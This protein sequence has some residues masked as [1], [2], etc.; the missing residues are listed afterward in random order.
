MNEV[1]IDR[2]IDKQNKFKQKR[3]QQLQQIVWKQSV[4]TP[5]ERHKYGTRNWNTLT[6]FIITSRMQDFCILLYLLLDL[7]KKKISI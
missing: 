4:K 3:Q 5:R 1:R 6:V 7:Q 2:H